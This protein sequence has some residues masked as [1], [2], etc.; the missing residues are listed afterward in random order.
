M[1]GGVPRMNMHDFDEVVRL[2]LKVLPDAPNRS[3]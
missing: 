1:D 3:S 2:M